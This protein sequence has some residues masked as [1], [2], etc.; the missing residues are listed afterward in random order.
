MYA[1]CVTNLAALDRGNLFCLAKLIS[2]AIN[3][4]V[5]TNSSGIGGEKKASRRSVVTDLPTGGSR[6]CAFQN[7]NLTLGSTV[8]RAFVALP[9][10]TSRWLTELLPDRRQSGNHPERGFEEI[11]A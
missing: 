9:S 11:G 10:I 6:S 2:R 4:V 7:E 5:F 1:I 3:A 8:C